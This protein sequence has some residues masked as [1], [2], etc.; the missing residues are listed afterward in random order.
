MLASK[1]FRSRRTQTSRVARSFLAVTCVMVTTACTSS[2]PTPEPIQTDIVITI[3]RAGDVPPGSIFLKPV[4]GGFLGG[5][6]DEEL[7]RSRA[8]DDRVRIPLDALSASLDDH[9]LV[10]RSDEFNPGELASPRGL[11]IARVGTFYEPA[12]RNNTCNN[13]RTGLRTDDPAKT[14]LVY[15][16]RAATVRG[17]R[18]TAPYIMN[19]QLEFPAAGLYVIGLRTHGMVVT[20]QVIN[21]AN[22]LI[23]KVRRAPCSETVAANDGIARSTSTS[24]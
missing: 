13:F 19:Y 7:F 4:P 21:A 18:Y 9:A 17:I 15:V 2:P 5:T 14:M 16:D 10:A 20:Q 22:P 23:A 12:L 8:G 3:D 24:P 11:R 1:P 6:L